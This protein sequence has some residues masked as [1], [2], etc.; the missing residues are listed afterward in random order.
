MPNPWTGNLI[1]RMHNERVTAS[2]MA[3]EMGCTKAYVSMI[4]NG[5]REPEGAQER[6]ESAFAA[7]LARRAALDSLDSSNSSTA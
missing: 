6:F 3:D 5:A 4:F 7:I 2:E 1:G